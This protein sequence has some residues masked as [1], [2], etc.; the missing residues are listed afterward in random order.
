[1]ITVMTVQMTENSSHY[2]HNSV[3]HWTNDE[4]KNLGTNFDEMVN[5]L[6]FSP[7]WLSKVWEN[8]QLFGYHNLS[9]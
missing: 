8:T 7:E 4:M 2:K 5:V 1:M 9:K 6:I 3:F